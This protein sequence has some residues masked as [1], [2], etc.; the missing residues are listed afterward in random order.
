MQELPTFG[1]IFVKQL[2]I[3]RT[4]LLI[5][6][7]VLYTTATLAQGVNL[8]NPPVLNFSRKNFK[9]GTQTWDIAR[10]KN[11]VM[12]F[13]NNDG[14]VEFDGTHWRLYPLGNGTIVRSVQVGRDDHI[15]VGGQGDFGYFSPDERGRLQYHSLKPLIP[16]TGQNFSD[17][18]DV[19]VQNE[20]VFFRTDDQVYRW[21]EQ[22]VTPLFPPG[23]SLFFMGLWKDKVL[24]QDGDLSFY[25][26][27]NDRFQ[28]LEHPGAFK[29]GRISSVLSLNTDTILVTTIQDGIFFFNGQTFEPW[30]TQDDPFLKTNRIFCA[31][32]LTDGK[33]AL[34][35]SLN[36]VVTLDLQRRIFHHLNKKSGL[37]NNSVLSLFATPNG[38]LWLGLDNGIDY[39]DFS[40][41]FTTLFPDG[42][43]QGTGYAAHIFNGKIYFG[44]NSGL[45]ATD[46]KSYYPPAERQKFSP[47][48]NSGGQVWSLNELGNSLLLG[49]HE[50]AFL[51]DGLVAR[52]LTNLPGVW[53]FV[54]LSP[55]MAV[56]GHYNGLGVFKKSG[57]NWVFDATLEGLTESSRILAK[58]AL[59]NIWMAHPYRGVYRIRIDPEKDR[60]TADF[61]NAQQGLPSELGN[62]LFQLGDRVVFTGEQGVFNF[63]HVQN[64][65]LPDSRFNAIFGEK[66]R[67]KYLRQDDTGDIWYATGHETGVLDVEDDALEKKV[68]RIPIPEL[69][70]KLTG[71]F[72]FILPVDR[73]NVFVATGQGFIHFDPASYMPRDSTI[74]IVL[75]SVRLKNEADSVLFGGFTSPDGSFPRIVLPSDQNTI[76]F[77]FSAT[78]YPGGEFVRYAHHLEGAEREWSD[79]NTE[80]D[81]VFNNLHPGNYT[82]HVKA[83]N[84]HGVESTVLSFPFKIM[85]PWY[86][87]RLAYFFYALL[88]LAI[89]AG[90]IY[91]QQKRFEQEKQDMQQ[92]HQRREEQHQL[93]ARRSEEAINRLQNEK[94]EAEI[95]HKTQELASATM[96]LVQKNEILFSI[97]DTL[98]KLQRKVASSPGLNQEVGKIIKMMEHDVS[99]DSDWE[100]FSHNFDQVHSDFLKRLGE[101]YPHLSPNDYKLCAYLRINLSSKEIASLM[102]ISLR[103]VEASRYRLRKRLDLDTEVNLTEFL[104]RF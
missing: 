68:K 17:V 84:Q 21:H 33:I 19:L 28:P 43:L 70:D 26:F 79:W 100:H 77:A 31:T 20:G 16:E 87:S 4:F 44:T 78:D 57:N 67:V 36:G 86:A 38:S 61:F 93:Q 80:S 92:R 40:S 34:G 51:V 73:H 18:W 65:F 7:Y 49:H 48:I 91:R 88:L 8:G 23:K 11:G 66:T 103:G 47:V 5:F 60:L 98:E 94:L 62:H 97:K 15:Y 52:K 83:R 64:R 39:V 29:N 89:G 56:A 53:R 63:D 59:G 24:V 72:P 25:V 22:R 27:E 13:G 58:D 74:R 9:A 42:D 12:W 6:G 41:P 54:R 55:E 76:G 10:D 85:P 96:H 1:H 45:Y 3:V 69:T 82:F 99:I 101:Q 81:L 35:T 46:W 104:M 37:Q 75:Q 90:I 95:N 102:N 2:L 32:R 71:G 30:K 50:G 14:L